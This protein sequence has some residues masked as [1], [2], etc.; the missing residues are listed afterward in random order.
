MEGIP[1]VVP[2]RFAASGLVAQTTSGWLSLEAVFV[3]CLT[4]PPKGAAIEL[5]I[6][7][8][9]EA[10]LEEVEGVVG[11]RVPPET[12]S[13]VG[14]WA[15]FRPVSVASRRRIGRFLKGRN[16][17]VAALA[18]RAFPRA[19]LCREVQLRGM[20]TADV[21]HSENISRAGMFIA[22]PKPPA[23]H[24]VVEVKLS[25]PDGL[26]AVLTQAEVV[27]RVLPE[28]HSGHAGAGLQ[29]IG[30]DDAFRERVDLCV[31]NLLAARLKT[32]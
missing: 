23:L 8:P 9:G 30:A 15:R 25:L 13:E 22:T 7:L 21:A 4:A 20:S 24:E 10:T 19:P 16:A 31:D 18:R 17:A 28:Q 14:F 3:R 27:Q 29:F 5:R 2:V 26:G 1:I 12:K 32:A 11:E 6:A